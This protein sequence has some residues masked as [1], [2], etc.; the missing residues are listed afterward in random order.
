MADDPV[1][2]AG[3][4][5]VS[6]PVLLTVVDG[7]VA[8]DLFQPRSIGKGRDAA[9]DDSASLQ[10][11]EEQDVEGG[12]AGGRPDFCGEEV[13]GPKHFLVP[14]NELGPGGVAL[15]LRGCPQAVS[16]ENITDGLVGDSMPQIGQCADDAVIAPAWILA[17]ELEHQL[18]DLGRDERSSRFGGASAGKIPFAGDQAAMPFEQ[19][20]GLHDGDDLAQQLAERFAFFGKDPALGI[21]E[22]PAR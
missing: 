21:V 4:E 10:G 18:F 7:E 5:L 20:F 16:I 6:L 15:A 22:A 13:G 17:G 12:Q 2:V 3:D 9:E 14:A 1:E 11:K 19:G 8:G